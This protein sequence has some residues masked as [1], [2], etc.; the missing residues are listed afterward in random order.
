MFLVGSGHYRDNIRGE[1]KTKNK[2]HFISSSRQHAAFARVSNKRNHRDARAAP[3]KRMP[4]LY[5]GIR[6]STQKKE[7]FFLF[8]FLQIV[9]RKI[10]IF[11]YKFRGKVEMK[12]FSSK[13]QMPVKNLLPNLCYQ[14]QC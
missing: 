8:F 3:D 2:L 4:E 14:L 10:Q 1:K 6:K 9:R 12:N 11:A 7:F 5:L 13:V